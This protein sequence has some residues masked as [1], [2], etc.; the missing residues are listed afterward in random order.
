MWSRRKKRRIPALL[1]SA[2]LLLSGCDAA[3]EQTQ[4]A[5]TVQPAAQQEE[6]L[7]VMDPNDPS[8]PAGERRSR[9]QSSRAASRFIPIPSF[10][11]F[12]HSI[13]NS[14]KRQEKTVRQVSL[15]HGFGRNGAQA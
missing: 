8:A 13:S 11:R 9:A 6:M 4:P 10:V 12:L 14:E 3:P 5:Q 7:P 1:L 2:V 15:S